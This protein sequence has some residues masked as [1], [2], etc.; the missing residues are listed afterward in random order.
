MFK[1]AISS[2]VEEKCLLVNRRD[3]LASLE[4]DG[5]RSERPDPVDA[6]LLGEALGLLRV[7]AL[8]LGAE[9]RGPPGPRGLDVLEG[10]RALLIRRVLSREPVEG[11]LGRLA[12]GALGVPERREERRER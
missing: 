5:F 11:P 4:V 9:D 1:V 7:E 8:E 12:D 3:W 2:I 10:R 6:R